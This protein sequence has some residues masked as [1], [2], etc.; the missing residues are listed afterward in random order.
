M[1]WVILIL[2]VVLVL[3]WMTKHRGAASPS[4]TSRERQLGNAS[5]SADGWLTI[6][7]IGYFGQY[8]QSPNGRYTLSWVESPIM[9]G[10]DGRS[11]K[12]QG[13]YLMMD[14]KNVVVNGRMPRP[15][16]GVVSDVGVFAINDWTFSEG[17]AGIFN[18]ISPRGDALL[19]ARFRA[20]LNNCGLSN[21]GR[22]AVCQTCNSDHEAHSGMLFFFDVSNGKLLWK[23]EPETGWAS[24]YEFDVPNRLLYLCYEGVGKY[25]YTFEGQCLD[26]ERW[27]Q[28]SRAKRLQNPSGYDLVYIAEEKMGEIE[29]GKAS[30]DQY[31]EVESMLKRSVGMDISE[32][33][34]A[35]AHRRLG[36]IAE[37]LGRPSDAIR[38]YERALELNPKVGC[39]RRLA[40]LKQQNA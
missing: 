40:Q 23:K 39:K 15:N 17:L 2:V 35:Q 24:G 3:W 30:A 6:D 28:E 12:P 1:G 38:E 26:E 25:R 14:G 33:T 13:T 9:E 36:E 10:S 31:T 16:D 5:L 27:R 4:R 8:V 34:K 20:N 22:F 32:N 18:V 11:R 21:D 7:S 29:T 37:K 19:K